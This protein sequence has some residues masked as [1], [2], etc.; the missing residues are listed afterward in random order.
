MADF[1]N[2]RFA[3]K[4]QEWETPI[5]LFNILNQEFNFTFDVCADENNKKT[6][7]YFSEQDDALSREWNGICWMNPPYKDL[8]L[9]VKKAYLESRH[10]D[11]TVVCLVPARTNTN[12]F[13][14][15]CMKGEIRFI[16]GRPKFKGCEHGLPQPLA[17]IVF[18]LDY[19]NNYKSVKLK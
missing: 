5:E 2:N 18:G 3:S 1:D 4:N 7:D 9:W 6:N 13:H 14:E 17:I 8:K 12:W 10:K 11:C 16:K 19:Q 15:Y